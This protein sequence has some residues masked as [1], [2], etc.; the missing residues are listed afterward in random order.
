MS[1]R[2]YI[3]ITDLSKILNYG[4]MHFYQDIQYGEAEL[5]THSIQRNS[6]IGKTS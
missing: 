1:Y 2:I 4:T 5:N 3:T 6:S